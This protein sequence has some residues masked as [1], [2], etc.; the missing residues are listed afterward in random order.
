MNNLQ[1][2]DLLASPNLIQQKNIVTTHYK[3]I[4]RHYGTYRGL[5][6]ARKHLNIYLERLGVSKG[7]RQSILRLENHQKVIRDFGA[8]YEKAAEKIAA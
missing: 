4:L 2:G 5:R 3:E 6:I 1:T 8:I 7:E